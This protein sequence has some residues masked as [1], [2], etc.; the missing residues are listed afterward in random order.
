[1]P[2]RFLHLCLLFL[3]LPVF[4]NSANA[5]DSEQQIKPATGPLFGQSRM[6]AFVLGNFDR[7]ASLKQPLPA[8]SKD[9]LRFGSQSYRPD[10]VTFV[11]ESFSGLFPGTYDETTDNVIEIYDADDLSA[12]VA[13]K[14]R[15]LDAKTSDLILKGIQDS[16][17]CWS[18]KLPTPAKDVPIILVSQRM[19]KATLSKCLYRSVMA[20]MGV[21]AL[22]KDRYPAEGRLD[23]ILS[24]M[25]NVTA[26]HLYFEC[27]QHIRKTD[28]SQARRCVEDRFDARY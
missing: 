1:M 13:E 27:R 23:A 9:A 11:L 4:A 2:L 21:L 3:L 18:G 8:L 28:F 7:F 19:D 26:M 17:L 10:D 25:A 6:R 12:Q 5:V 16:S 20:Q 24:H 15:P 22:Y 14:I